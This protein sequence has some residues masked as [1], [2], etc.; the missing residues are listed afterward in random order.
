M[1]DVKM[2]LE[3]GKCR[4][5]VSRMTFRLPQDEKWIGLKFYTFYIIILL[6]M[7]PHSIDFLRMIKQIGKLP[8]NSILSLRMLQDCILVSGPSLV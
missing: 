6:Y 8:E 7:F 3:K 5:V 2:K 4:N 1:E